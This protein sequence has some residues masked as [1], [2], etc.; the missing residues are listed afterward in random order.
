MPLC[1]LDFTLILIVARIARAIPFGTPTRNYRGAIQVIQDS[2]NT[3]LGYISRFAVNGGKQFGYD[4]SIANALIVDF[5]APIAAAVTSQI[6]VSMEVSYYADESPIQFPT[7][8][9]IG[10]PSLRIKIP[11]TPSS[12]LFRD[13]MM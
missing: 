7:W 3:A 6:E 1:I 13:V 5:T 11:R 8:Q 12:A 2:D 4:A 9:T 10:S